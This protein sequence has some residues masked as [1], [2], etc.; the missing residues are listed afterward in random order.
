MYWMMV[1]LMYLDSILYVTSYIIVTVFIQSYITR[2]EFFVDIIE[3]KLAEI[4]HAP[5]RPVFSHTSC[6]NNSSI[7]IL[8]AKIMNH[9]CKCPT[10]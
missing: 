9:N 2:S 7:I 5:K 6:N 10:Y 1:F 3:N 8:F 4:L